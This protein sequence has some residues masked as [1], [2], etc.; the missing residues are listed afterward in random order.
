MSA[1]ALAPVPSPAIPSHV[2]CGADAGC[3]RSIADP[4]VNLAIWERA[5]TPVL[6]DEAEALARHADGEVRVTAGLG[7]AARGLADAMAAAGWP[8]APALIDDVGALAALAGPV[9]TAPAVDLRLAIVTGDACR[10]FHADYVPL[11][12]ITSYAGAG[13]QWLSNDDAAALAAGAAT[14]DLDIRQLA[15]GDVALFKG[16]LLSDAPII[17][18][19]PPI[20]GTGARRLVL[21]INPAVAG[22]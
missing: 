20:A 14:G 11:R 12:L 10:K 5:L 21:V 15:T 16:R 8:A 22:D 2:A 1:L 18:R 6:A 7:A 19:S 17:H 13:S 3:L 9:M 4:A